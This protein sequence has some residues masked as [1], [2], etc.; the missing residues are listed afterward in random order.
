MPKDD[1][2]SDEDED[3]F[4]TAVGILQSEEA[5]AYQ[6]QVVEVVRRGL[7]KTF[8]RTKPES[9]TRQY[10]LDILDDPDQTIEIVQK[11]SQTQPFKKDRRGNESIIELNLDAFNTD[12]KNRILQKVEKTYQ[13]QGRLLSTEQEP[14]LEIIQ[15]ANED[16]RNQEILDFFGEYTSSNQKQL[17]QR[18]LYI[19]TAWES[20]RYIPDEQINQWKTDLENKFGK[21]GENVPNLCSS[22]YYDQDRVMRKIIR[23]IASTY[24]QRE[25]I[26]YLYNEV[27]IGEPFVVYVGR[28]D[29][30]WK[31][32]RELVKKLKQYD[33]YEYSVPFVDL[34]AR[35]KR[36]I[37]VAE[38]V[39]EE[40]KE[41]TAGAEFEE[42]RNEYERCYRIDPTTTDDLVA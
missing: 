9:D 2:S 17:L 10:N 11:G 8:S 31:T 13:E 14:E 20:N 3:I 33:I 12:Q 15:N 41:S 35:G 21:P 18:S 6:N 26:E 7:R 4:A 40:V 39:V 23:Q 16:D 28:F 37:E 42:R 22:G 36:N 30:E 27:V 25:Q 29:S 38:K 34:R 32:L 24:D 19:R 1:Q 5:I